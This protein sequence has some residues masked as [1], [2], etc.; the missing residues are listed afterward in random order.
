MT[1]TVNFTLTTTQTG[2]ESVYNTNHPN[3]HTN[4][5]LYKRLKSN[6]QAT[7]T[8]RFITVVCL[9]VWHTRISQPTQSTRNVRG[10]Y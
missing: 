9:R 7:I 3:I 4:L 2:T 10:T 5:Y 6:S 8:L 1:H